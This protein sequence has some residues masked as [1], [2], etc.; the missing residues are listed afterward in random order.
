MTSRERIKTIFS[1][2]NPDRSGFWLGNP[3]TE[4]W[5]IYF[6]HFGIRNDRETPIDGGKSEEISHALTGFTAEER[7]RQ[8]LSDDFRWICPQWSSYKHP[9]KKP[10]WENMHDSQ[11]GLASAGVFS[12]CEDVR[13][14]ENFPWPNPDY[15]DFTETLQALKSSGNVYRASGMWCCFFHDVA[16]FFGMENYF[17]KMYTHPEVVEAVT[18]KVCKFYLAANER[19]FEEANGEVDG[20]F[21]GNDFG[22]QLDLLISPAQFDRFIMPWF[23]KFTEQGH[24]H[25][26]QVILHSCGAIHKVI[27]RLIE[28]RVDA[29]HPLQAKATDMDAACLS[30]DFRGKIAF[31]GGVDTQELLV[32]ATP[33]QVRSEVR[34]IAAL[35]GP[36]LVVSPSH[37]ALLPNVPPENVI[38]MSEA[39]T[40]NKKEIQ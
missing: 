12:D 31:M 2:G 28:A 4:T 18:G 10:I 17:V 21:F 7:L 35:L 19:F 33:D 27:D 30:R 9:M 34:R 20:F 40:I 23:R 16:D 32:S 39:A 38:A 36:N 6:K 15:L 25:G 3:H 26:C 29:L 5:P 8:K 11:N 13:D 24:R 1:G 37:E 22:T 14:I